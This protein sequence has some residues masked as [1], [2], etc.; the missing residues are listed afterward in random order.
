[1]TPEAQTVVIA[2][3]SAASTG[4]I[5]AVA[6]WALS[7]RHVRA[8]LVAAPLV[9][10]ASVGAGVLVSAR[11]MFIS[12]HDVF[13]V[14][15]IV[16]AAV[17]VALGY[18]LLLAR[19]VHRLDQ[20]AAQRVAE[21][22]AARE[23][24]AQVETHRRDLVAWASHD[25]R[26]PIAGIRAMAEALDDGVAPAAPPGQGYAARI[27]AEADRMGALVE[28]L[29]SLSRIQSG[30]LQLSRE[31]VSVADLVSDA[32]ASAQ[33]RAEAAGIR[34]TGSAEGPVI[35]EV[36][37][38]ELARVLD[39]LVG[40]ALR[41]TPAGGRVCV[42]AATRVDPPGDPAGSR[43]A[44]AV[45]RVSDTCGGLTE[46]TRQRMFEP[47][48]RADQ[49]RTRATGEGAGLG[50]AVVRGIVEAHGGTV[51]VEDSPGGCTVVVA[52]PA[53]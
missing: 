9:V 20:Q 53:D 26:S 40:N 19:R 3:G 4:A 41:A 38:R 34:L 22:A 15:L 52:L 43:V 5:G 48:W 13:L 51:D 21:A 35:A 16:L 6:V 39:N 33:A 1:M 23:R 46:M 18:G 14:L 7:R 31:P 24:D 37:A 27:R 36:D 2:A 28:D 8:A 12:E 25:L 11:S 29:L 10:N 44:R 47:W 49:A 45:V 42:V 50:L 30:R 17:P 32:L